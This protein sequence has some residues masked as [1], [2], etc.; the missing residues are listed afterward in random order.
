MV[1][2]TKRFLVGN[3]FQSRI[4]NCWKVGEKQQIY[5][6]FLL[7][8]TILCCFLSNNKRWLSLYH[9]EKKGGAE[10]DGWALSPFSAFCY[11]NFFCIPEDLT[12]LNS[13]DVSFSFPV[14]RVLEPHVEA[15]PN[16]WMLAAR[17]LASFTSPLMAVLRR[18]LSK[19]GCEN[20]GSEVVTPPQ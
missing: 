12:E 3:F 8:N 14:T 18:A 9:R 6:F 5:I 20:E 2:N 7:K 19:N 17:G 4:K 15:P 11:E 13:G 1:K 10:M 16:T